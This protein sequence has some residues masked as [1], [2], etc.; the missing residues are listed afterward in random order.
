MR[1]VE[2]VIVLCIFVACLAVTTGL[3]HVTPDAAKVLAG[4]SEAYRSMSTL[5][6]EGAMQVEMHAPGMETKM[7]TRQSPLLWA[8]PT[9]CAWR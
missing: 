8:P 7:E 9:K 6:A 3:A 5:R 1:K 2:R 4:V